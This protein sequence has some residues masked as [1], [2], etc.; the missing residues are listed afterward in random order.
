MV[1]SR[2]LEANRR[3]RAQDSA[4]ASARRGVAAMC[5]VAIALIHLIDVH[6]KFDEVAYI[7]VLFVGLIVLSL[8]LAEAL[9]RSDEPSVWMAAC[10]LAAATIAGY[11]LS[12]SVGLPGEGGEEIGN[13]WEGLGLA[14][15]LVESLVVWLAASRLS[16]RAT[17]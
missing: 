15:L 16:H 8:V 2:K 3:V 5:L 17:V 7:G 12:R 1:V 13:W 4:G 14:S 11:A 10:L 9:L 6:D